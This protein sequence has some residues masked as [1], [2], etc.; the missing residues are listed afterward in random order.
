[1]E[2]N[3]YSLE[4]L[5][6]EMDT[7]A[8]GSEEGLEQKVARAL[9]AKVEEQGPEQEALK[10]AALTLQ[11]EKVEDHLRALEYIACAVSKSTYESY[12]FGVASVASILHAA[13]RKKQGPLLQRSE[14]S[15]GSLLVEE[16]D[17][18]GMVQLGWV[19][20]LKPVEE[21]AEANR[22]IGIE[23]ETR[24]NSLLSSGLVVPDAGE[25]GCRAQVRVGTALRDQGLKV[26]L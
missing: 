21:E 14:V 23:L 20:H 15:C 3:V 18:A 16:P 10:E 26:G 24:R 11:V 2:K 1:M 9:Q 13:M 22:Q 17:E 7:V 19:S 6:L 25:V 5:T 8:A 4:E 12:S